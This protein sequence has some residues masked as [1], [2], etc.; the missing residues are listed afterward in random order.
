MTK[1]YRLGLD[2]DGEN[3]RPTVVKRVDIHEGLAEAATTIVRTPDTWDCPCGTPVE[4]V[5][6]V[7]ADGLGLYCDQAC[8]SE[9]G[10]MAQLTRL[11]QNR[12]GSSGWDEEPMA[13]WEYDLMGYEAKCGV[14]HD[15]YLA[16]HDRRQADGPTLR[17]TSDE[18]PAMTDWD[19]VP[20]YGDPADVYDEDEDLDEGDASAWCPV[21]PLYDPTG[22]SG[23]E[24]AY[25]IFGGDGFI[26][27][28]GQSFGG[29]PEGRK[30][31]RDEWTVTSLARAW[32]VETS[33]ML[34]YLRDETLGNQSEVTPSSRVPMHVIS[35]RMERERFWP[36][37]AVDRTKMWVFSR[38]L[39]AHDSRRP[40]TKQQRGEEEYGYRLLRQSQD[41][42][43]VAITDEC[44][45]GCKVMRN[46]LGEIKVVH[47][48][49]YGCDHPKALNPWGQKTVVAQ[50]PAP[51]PA[52]TMTTPRGPRPYWGPRPGAPRPG[53]NPFTTLGRR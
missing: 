9:H 42:R 51:R 19:D 20:E 29:R 7:F 16:E 48:S 27:E 21:V 4:M 35:D 13:D 38:M 10:E 39:L 8:F 31:D 53:N 43:E 32:D 18:P 24:D 37:Y 3:I 14:T 23:R 50:P 52:N 11:L 45:F 15:E 40:D 2:W 28:G 22:K 46:G 12:D 36:A 34:S 30:T 5:D 25:S 17:W 26:V 49:V 33:V 47:S 41:W 6:G 1:A 44:R